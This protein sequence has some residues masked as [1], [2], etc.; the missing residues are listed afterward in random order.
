[1]L[2][3][4]EGKVGLIVGVANENSIAWGCAKKI[5]ECKAKLAIT[6]GNEKTQ[7]YTRSLAE[8]LNCPIFLPLNVQKSEEVANLFSTIEKQWGKLDFLL[9]S[10]A[11]CPQTDLHGR[12]VDCSKEGFLTAM[13]VSCYSLINLSKLVEPFMKQ[14]GSI[15]TISYYGSNKVVKNYNIMGVAKAALESTARYLASE[16][17]ERNIRVNVISPGPIATRAASGIANF[18]DLLDDSTAKSPLHRGV[19]IYSVGNLAAFMVSDL[20]KD[21]TG[22]LLYVDAG[23]SIIA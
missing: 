1:M 22:D 19:D 10:I 9:H 14:G 23:S 6:Y 21:I 17:G 5:H 16:L 18:K 13:E 20:S 7:K 2:I 15:L 11:F 12:V 8:Q 4:L 3:D